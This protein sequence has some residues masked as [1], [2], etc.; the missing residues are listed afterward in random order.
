M[1]LSVLEIKYIWD[2]RVIECDGANWDV[3]WKECATGFADFVFWK[4]ESTDADL[5]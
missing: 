2:T 1:G 5:I 4:N 3:D